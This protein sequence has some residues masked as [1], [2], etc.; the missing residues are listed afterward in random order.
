MQSRLKTPPLVAVTIY[1]E[2]GCWTEHGDQPPTVALGRSALEKHWMTTGATPMVTD[3]LYFDM[4]LPGSV[5][6]SARI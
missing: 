3:P 1:T 5:V 4:F 2:G 6:R